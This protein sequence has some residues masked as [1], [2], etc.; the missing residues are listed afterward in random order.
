MISVSRIVKLKEKL[1]QGMKS[2]RTTGRTTG[3]LTKEE[4]CRNCFIADRMVT[5]QNTY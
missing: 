1:K 4:E 5:K 3:R 2:G